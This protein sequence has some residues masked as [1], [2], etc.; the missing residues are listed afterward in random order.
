MGKQLLRLN[1]VGWGRP[2]LEPRVT[3]WDPTHEGCPDGQD[4]PSWWAAPAWALGFPMGSGYEEMWFSSPL[5][6]GVSFQSQQEKSNY[7]IRVGLQLQD[8]PWRRGRAPS[9]DGTGSGLQSH[10]GLTALTT[11]RFPQPHVAVPNMA[12]SCGDPH[13]CPAHL[14]PLGRSWQQ[15]AQHC[16]WCGPHQ[17]LRGH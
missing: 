14:W 5:I 15:R 7:I 11:V 4:V 2:C 13:P 3:L 6:P 9:P 17:T 8:S 12:A 1:R 16:R 10:L